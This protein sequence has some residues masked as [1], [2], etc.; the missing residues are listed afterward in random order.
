MPRAKMALKNVIFLLKI[1]LKVR[2][3][4]YTIKDV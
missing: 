4:A 1:V 3:V 2:P